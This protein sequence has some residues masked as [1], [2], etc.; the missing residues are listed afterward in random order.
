MSG[1]AAHH[2]SAAAYLIGQVIEERRRFGHPIPPWL[3]DLEAALNR[4]LSAGGNQPHPDRP[5]WKTT[6]Q[7]AA[8]WGCTTRT[9]RNRA[10]AAGGELVAGRWLIR[11][12][13]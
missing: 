11:E 13:I 10:R 6:K 4:E 8:E 5:V 9:V 7:L 12:D 3:R 1:L 2:I